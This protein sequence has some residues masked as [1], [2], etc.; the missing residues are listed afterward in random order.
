MY[1]RDRIQ[2]IERFREHVEEL[3]ETHYERVSTQAFRHAAFQLTAPDPSL[4]DPQVIELTAI[5]KS[6]D[7]EIDGWFVDDTSEQFLIFQSSGGDEKVSEGK[8]SKFWESVQEVLNPERVEK[9]YNQS[10][11]ELSQQLNTKLRDEYSLRMVFVAKAGFTPSADAFAR[12]RS[13]IDRAIMLLDANKVV[14]PC[15]LELLNENDLAMRFEDY[16]A[17]FLA[18]P[19]DVELKIEEDLCYAVERQDLKSLRATVRAS[20]IV[21]IFRTP[22]MGYRLFLLN[23]RGP[24]ANAKVNKNIEKTLSSADG[25]KTFH[26]LNNGLCATCDGFE[27]RDGR[28][29][30]KNFQIVNGCQ[31]TVTLEKR[32]QAELEE[33][34]IDLKLAIADVALAESIAT[35]SNSQTALR[36]KDYASFERLQRQLQYEFAA[37]Q[38]PWYYEIKQGYWRFVLGDREKARFKTGRRKRHIEVQPLA[39]ASLAFSGYPADA[40]DRVRFVFQGIRSLE[41]REWY[42]RAFP[43]DINVQQL[44][45][46][47]LMLDFIEKQADRE[48][49]ATFHILW[50][51]GDV[52]KKHY[53]LGQ[54]DYLSPQTSSQLSGSISEWMWGM[55]RNA[56]VACRMAVRRASNIMK[57]SRIDQRDFFRASG[58]MSPGVIPSEL[59]KEACE[60]ELQAAIDEKKDPRLALPGRL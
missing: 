24:I 4:S 38:P 46:P 56:N 57:E 28:L 29:V 10:V 31:T 54:S 11:K 6:G 30:I 33:T 43:K 14:I 23:P 26:L 1:D 50:L 27:E 21:R 16:R 39:Q 52:L 53:Q 13:H 37:L 3:A 48:R 7:L 19:T 9:T 58:E 55:F 35:A 41:D 2:I 45:V 34:L 22:G 17:G 49:F 44:L 5:D 12:S 8:V 42:E 51:I 47:W 25:R 20:E 18:A 32:T 59:L 60:D 40:L 36:A 15:T